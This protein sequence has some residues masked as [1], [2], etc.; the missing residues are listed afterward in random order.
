MSANLVKL[1]Q[2]LLPGGAGHAMEWI[3]GQKADASTTAT[4]FCTMVELRNFY[5]TAVQKT[6]DIHFADQAEVLTFN[7]IMGFRD[8]E[9]TA[10]TYGKPD[11]C[12]KLDG[13]TLDGSEEEVRYKY[14]PTHSEPAVCCVPNYTR[15]FTYYLDQMWVRADDGIA[16][17]LYGRPCTQNF[18]KNA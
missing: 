11:N 10:I 13:H 17:I 15:N 8:K 14:S 6:G 18:S 5:G 3:S 1:D 4:E 2:C 7:G 9:G 12:Y 16:A